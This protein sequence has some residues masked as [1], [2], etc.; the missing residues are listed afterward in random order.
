MNEF[1][2]YYECFSS[3]FFG[4]DPSLRVQKKM[5]PVIMDEFAF[6]RQA[7]SEPRIQNEYQRGLKKVGRVTTDPTS[8]LAAYWPFDGDGVEEIDDLFV[9]FADDPTAVVG[10]VNSAIRFTELN[11]PAGVDPLPQINFGKGTSGNFTLDGWLR[12][13]SKAEDIVVAGWNDG[14]GEF[15]PALLVVTGVIM[16]WNRVLRKGGKN[17]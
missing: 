12:P 2:N 8:G 15:A 11:T 13:V 14:A 9:T 4:A 7:L 10:Q 16:W 3:L 6:W 5:T 17:A 1:I